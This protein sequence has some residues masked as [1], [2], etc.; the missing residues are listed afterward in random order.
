MTKPSLE[1]RAGHALLQKG[2]NR[3]RHGRAARRQPA[4]ASG[5]WA[6]V[7]A[8]PTGVNANPPPS[9]AIGAARRQ[10]LGINP[11]AWLTIGRVAR[12]VGKELGGHGEKNGIADP[13]VTSP[14]AHPI[15]PLAGKRQPQRLSVNDLDRS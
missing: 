3:R 4:L 11:E 15:R 7:P 2:Q 10:A 8:P 13:P 6:I 1:E 14:S 5:G 12:G 9:I